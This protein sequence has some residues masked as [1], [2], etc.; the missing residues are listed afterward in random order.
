MSNNFSLLLCNLIKFTRA[1]F[2]Q[3][4]PSHCK[5]IRNQ[6]ALR[7]HYTKLSLQLHRRASQSNNYGNAN[8]DTKLLLASSAFIA[9][10]KKEEDE[11][12]KET[13]IWQKILPKD[14]AI[15]FEEREPED[16]TPEG[17]LIMT[18]KRTILLIDEQKLDK[19]EQMIHLALRMA[20]AIQHQDGITLCFDIMANL[21]FERQQFEK[22]E[23]LFVLV[24]QRML[25]K[26]IPQND[27]QLLHISLKI[28]QIADNQGLAEK[29]DLGY[30]WTLGELKRKLKDKTEDPDGYEIWGL[31]NDWYVRRSNC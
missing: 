17:R 12:M 24:M 15:L 22:A 6:N 3:S 9:F 10:F 5:C 20:Q 26:G 11:Q 31:A 28:A 18:I 4:F 13:S 30:T 14:L 1:R 16:E 2:L 29:A 8:C 27:N 19:A 21:A 25:Q 7:E 23:K